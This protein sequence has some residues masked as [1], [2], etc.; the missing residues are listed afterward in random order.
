LDTLKELYIGG[1]SFP[2]LPKSIGKLKSLEI[3][4]FGTGWFKYGRLNKLPTSIGDLESLR[5][6]DLSLNRLKEL[7]E[8]IGKLKNLESLKLNQNPIEQLPDSLVNLSALKM[9]DISHTQIDQF[10]LKAYDLVSL[11]TVRVSSD[12]KNDFDGLRDLFSSF[13]SIRNNIIIDIEFD[14]KVQLSELFYG[15]SVL[16]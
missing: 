1:N 15:K 4:V 8:S 3:L 16:D 6:L 7:P 11:E 9:L 14:L 2:E 10:P 13:K 12:Y 5:E